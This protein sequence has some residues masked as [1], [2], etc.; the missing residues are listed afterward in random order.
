MR[1]KIEDSVVRSKI[2]VPPFRVAKFHYG[3]SVV[4]RW[5]VPMNEF[6][7]R[8]GADCASVVEELNRDAVDCRAD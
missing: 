6:I 5:G 2:M 4:N 3:D 7:D 8:E 1:V